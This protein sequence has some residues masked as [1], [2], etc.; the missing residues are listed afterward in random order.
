LHASQ[1]WLCYW[2]CQGLDLLDA[3][4]TNEIAKTIAKCQSPTTGGSGDDPTQLAHLA[5][6][7]AAI[8]TLIDTLEAHSVINLENLKR[9]LDAMR[10][11][12]GT[13][14]R[15]GEIDARASYCA[16]ASAYLV[17][18]EMDDLGKRTRSR[19]V[20]FKL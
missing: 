7:F 1:P 17:G 11:P 5:S 14:H 16:I 8:C 13:V 19:H 20:L 10:Q 6:T 9:F 15:G 18:L 4:N 12:D 3:P 2:T